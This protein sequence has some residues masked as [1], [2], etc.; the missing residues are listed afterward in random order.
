MASH[1]NQKTCTD[2]NETQI[3]PIEEIDTNINRKKL[4]LKI[5]LHIIPLLLLTYV[6]QFMDKL[7]VSNGSV[8]GLQEDNH[9][10]KDEYSWVSS[11]FYFGYLAG[12]IPTSRLVQLVP[13]GKFA[14]VT[15]LLWGIVLACSASC[16]SYE[17][18]LIARFF[19][20]L[21]ESCV[22]PIFVLITS[23][24]YTPL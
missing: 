6:L 7:A 15:V 14:G 17:G 12:Q 8:F 24:W 10:K 18:L 11:I 1:N 9:L 13:V 4:T 5:D 3:A 19:L 21:L 20:G 2:V 16:N 23:M 22:S